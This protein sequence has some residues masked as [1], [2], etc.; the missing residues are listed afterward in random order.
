MEGNYQQGRR[1]KI[2]I[3]SGRRWKVGGGAETQRIEE[4]AWAGILAVRQK[5]GSEVCLEV[6]DMGSLDG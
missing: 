3:R 4:S 2:H 6:W 1:E 5:Q